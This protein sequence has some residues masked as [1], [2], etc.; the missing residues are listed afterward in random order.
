[1]PTVLKFSSTAPLQGAKFVSP[2]A[3]V[4]KYIMKNPIST[5]SDIASRTWRSSLFRA[6]GTYGFFSLINS[7]IPFFLLPVMTRYLTPDDYGIVAIFAVMVS[8]LVPFI[9]MNAQ[10]AY[11]RAYFAPDRFDST[12]Y[13]GTV[14]VFILVSWFVIAALFSIFSDQVSVIF[15]FPSEWLWAVP[16]VA[17][18]TPSNTGHTGVMASAGNAPLLRYFSKLSHPV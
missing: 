3:A 12:R 8:L 4:N 11:S 6:A 18:G 13:M 10:G 17:L 16:I 15:T 14:M 1:M 5:I 9:G 2:L 7:A